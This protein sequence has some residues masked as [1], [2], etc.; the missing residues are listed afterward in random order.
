ML[1]RE[2]KKKG[3]FMEKVLK[4]F[5]KKIKT[6][7]ELTF[8]LEEIAQAQ[9][10][11]FKNKRGPLSKKVEGKVNGKLKN[12]LEKLEEEEVISKSPGQQSS[13]LEKLKKYLQSLPEIK[14]EIAFLPSNEFL[15]RVNQWF[16]EELSQKII[17][18]LITNSQIVG[19]AVIEYQG[20]WRNFSLVKEL[21]KL[22]SQKNL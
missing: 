2:Q 8:Y 9:Q 20:N 15:T 17:L 7:E 5:A 18:D 4:D 6:K 3:F 1:S 22:I 19:G 14:L 16:E 12:F 10:I 11:V 21:D 13:F